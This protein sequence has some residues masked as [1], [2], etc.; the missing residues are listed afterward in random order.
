[1]GGVDKNLVVGD[2]SRWGGWANFQMM[3]GLPPSPSVGKTLCIG[4]MRG[5]VKPLLFSCNPNIFA[6]NMLLKTGKIQNLTALFLTHIKIKI[7]INSWRFLMVF[8]DVFSLWLTP[9]VFSKWKG[10]KWY[11][12]CMSSWVL[13][14]QI[15]LYQ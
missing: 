8:S 13:N 10:L 3:G 7:L 12:Q 5:E 4:D 14:F 9:L 2:F 15:F 1:M 6:V 11:T